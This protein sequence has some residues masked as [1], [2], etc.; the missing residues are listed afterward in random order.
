MRY[1]VFFLVMSAG[2]VAGVCGYILTID[3]PEKVQAGVPLLVTG[4][5]T[6]PAGTE[7]DLVL[8]RLIQPVPETI[9]R[10]IVIV[11]ETKT[12]SESFSTL[13]LVPDQYKV[14]VAFPTDRS[15]SLG[16]GS[17][18]L[19]IF[20][21]VDRADEIVLTVPTEQS[22]GEALV[23]RGY[24]QDIGV[25]TINIKITGPSGFT[26][27][28]LDIRTTT[29]PGRTDGQFTRTVEVTDP[30][31]YY[32]TF[33]DAR[34]HMAT[35]KFTVASPPT[36]TETT[37]TPTENA[38]GTPPATIAP[39]PLVGMVLGLSAA[40]ALSILKERLEKR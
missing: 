5:T 29:M 10:R 7:F 36:A 24:I 12:F 1:L 16:S 26:A 15:T 11:D 9:E 27:P 21:I 39:F 20:T 19:K 30:G 33:S 35:I 38:T 40:A 17:T 6:F 23:I 25:A 13:G 4:S 3:A 34:G 18:T 28:A 2:L 37:A 8:Y 32:V 31:N 22:V 14:E